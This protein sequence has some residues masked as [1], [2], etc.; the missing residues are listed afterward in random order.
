MSQGRTMLAAVRDRER[1]RHRR[2]PGEPRST[3]RFAY[4]A[5]HWSYIRIRTWP[6]ATGLPAPVD[7]RSLILDGGFD[8]QVDDQPAHR[9]RS[10]GSRLRNTT[11]NVDGERPAGSADVEGSLRCGGEECRG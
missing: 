10:D 2:F 3:L 7:L 11:R 9:R 8:V 1:H 5:T 4:N 6:I